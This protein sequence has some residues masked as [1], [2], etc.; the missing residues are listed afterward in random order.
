ML[1]APD[2]VVVGQLLFFQEPIRLSIWLARRLNSWTNRHRH[3]R[4]P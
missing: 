4:E 2:S 1:L 3:R